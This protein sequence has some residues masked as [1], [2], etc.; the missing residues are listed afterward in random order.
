MHNSH[1]PRVNY[2]V[3]MGSEPGNHP[4]EKGTQA[5]ECTCLD[6]GEGKGAEC[7]PLST[8]L[9]YRDISTQ[10]SGQLWILRR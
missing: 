3:S 8:V 5:D 4:K 7:A 9:R 10:V 2:G 6:D 1:R